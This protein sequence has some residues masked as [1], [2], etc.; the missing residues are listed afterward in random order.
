MK[1]LL[2][3]LLFVFTFLTT[4]LFA[5]GVTIQN[6]RCE[7]LN[8]PPG[9]D[10]VNPRLSWMIESTRR[11]ERQTAFQILVASSTDK[12]D[13]NMGDLWDSRKVE[14]DQTT[15]LEYN[16]KTLLTGRQCFWK[17]RVW[18]SKGKVSGWSKPALWTMGLLDPK[19]WQAK[20]IG[21]N[22]P[23]PTEW[24]RPRCLRKPFQLDRSVLQVTVYVTALGLYEL[25]INGKRVGDHL[26][27]PKWTNYN[28]RVQYQTYDVTKMVRSDSNTIG[29][30]L[31]NGWYSG[32]WQQWKDKLRA[33]YGKEPLLL[34]QL[35]IEF[36]DGSRQTIVSDESWRGT[37]DG[38]L[39]FAGIYEG[40]T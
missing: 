23:S 20:W 40:V 13:R 5:S 8:N 10:V 9:I 35:E 39:Q 15:Q 14:S 33:I 30:I 25:R 27:T 11:G 19:D 26:L 12:L 37:A 7:Y 21:V 4:T 1:R 38:P 34:A 32:G 18:N 2:N 28:K 16:G 29:V 6:L 3:I 31:G 22:D 17:V 24:V 36:I